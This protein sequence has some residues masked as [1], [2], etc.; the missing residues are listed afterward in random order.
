MTFTSG[1][2]F[3]KMMGT[4]EKQRHYCTAC[5]NYG[6]KEIEGLPTN[7]S[8]KRAWIRR[9]KLVKK[10]FKPKTTQRLCSENFKD[11]H[12][13]R[14]YIPSIFGQKTFNTYQLKSTYTLH[15]ILIPIS[16]V[17]GL[18]SCWFGCVPLYVALI[19]A[20]FKLKIYIEMSQ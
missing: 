10:D 4:S 17:P 5:S 1:D 2:V 12:F 3:R 9:L 18:L 8:L 15:R 14:N 11:W 13:R 7:E 16:T 19:R 6:G 20:V